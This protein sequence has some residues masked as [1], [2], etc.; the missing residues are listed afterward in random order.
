MVD[1]EITKSVKT[2]IKVHP[3]N[4]KACASGCKFNSYN[5]SFFCDYYNKF[6]EK[7]LPFQR[8]NIK[9]YLTKRYYK[10]INTFGVENK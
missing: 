4:R 7:T 2:T 3:F 9:G 8:G 5:D 1:I 6:L 10:C